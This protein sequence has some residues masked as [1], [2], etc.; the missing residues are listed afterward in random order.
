MSYSEE[1]QELNKNSE[2][3]LE[4]LKMSYVNKDLSIDIYNILIDSHIIQK[5]QKQDKIEEKYG[6][7]NNK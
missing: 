4:S 7:N 6:L 1:M 3:Y 5:N 2:K